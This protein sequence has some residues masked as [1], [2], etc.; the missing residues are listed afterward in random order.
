MKTNRTL[1]ESMLLKNPRPFTVKAFPMEESINR[2]FPPSLVFF[3]REIWSSLVRVF[4][5]ERDTKY[6]EWSA[7]FTRVRT[8]T[9]HFC[10]LNKTIRNIWASD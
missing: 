2:E 10:A 8:R 3:P 9:L 4:C 1:D 5:F 7:I 6:S